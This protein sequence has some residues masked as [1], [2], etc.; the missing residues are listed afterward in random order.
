[1]RNLFGAK[2][3]EDVTAETVKDVAEKVAETITST[4]SAV[5]ETP[6]LEL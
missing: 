5:M 4:A 6:R 3:R 1:M 2:L